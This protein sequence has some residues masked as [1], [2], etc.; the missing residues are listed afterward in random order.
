MAA[1]SS[2]SHVIRLGLDVGGV[3][4][5]MH[6]TA[7]GD[8]IH[9]SVDPDMTA[10]AIQ[11]GECYGMGQLFVISRTKKGVRH[12]QH[13]RTKIDHFSIRVC[14]AAGLMRLGMGSD[15]IHLCKHKGG[16]NGKGPIAKN[17]GLTHFVDND[18]E[19]LRAISQYGQGIVEA[20]IFYD[21]SPVM[22]SLRRNKEI[23]ASHDWGDVQ[24]HVVES[25]VEIAALVGLPTMSPQKWI[26]LR[27]V[28]PPFCKYDP[29]ILDDAL[30]NE[31]GDGSDAAPSRTWKSSSS[32]SLPPPKA[33][34]SSDEPPVLTQTAK[35]SATMA[36]PG[37]VLKPTAKMPEPVIIVH[38]PAEEPEWARSMAAS[39]KSLAASAKQFA[40]P[41]PPPPPPPQP[42]Q[43]IDPDELKRAVS[44]AIAES[45]ASDNVKRR[46]MGTHWYTKKQQRAEMHAAT[47][48]AQ[49]KSS[50]VPV[51][52][53]LGSAP[54]RYLPRPAMCAACDKSQPGAYC[55]RGMCRPCCL[56]AA[57]SSD[58]KVCQQPQH[59]MP[60]Q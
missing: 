46:I 36:S 42:S 9:Q 26:K 54:H 52:K 10:F 16:V 12:S 43:Q 37:P 58:D 24:C 34:P 38:D 29:A 30:Q 48:V 33:R 8:D 14:K 17:L 41:S 53:A 51:S 45:L 44:T 49:S 6:S 20:V 55:C 39:A 19:N 57:R 7:D 13:G 15:Q 21:N 3:I 50:A 18:W 56:A 60:M 59:V 47:Q 1:S 32:S 22:S 4:S 28:T 25:W 5:R 35:G 40:A 31:P 11:F 23:A 2:A 27:N